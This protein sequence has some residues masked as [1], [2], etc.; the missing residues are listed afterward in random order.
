[1]LF[2][3]V[4]VGG[5]DDDG[6]KKK[7]TP[8]GATVVVVV[9]V[10]VVPF[11]MFECE[12]DN[13]ERKKDGD[14]GGGDIDDGTCGGD[15]GFS[16]TATIGDTE[17]SDGGKDNGDELD[18][19]EELACTNGAAGGGG[20]AGGV[21]PVVVEGDGRGE[22]DLDGDDTKDGDKEPGYGKGNDG[23]VGRCGLATCNR[24]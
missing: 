17:N 4:V 5:D 24:K 10:R 6:D 20:A 22:T 16:S 13:E 15:G 12:G 7:S 18:K 21:E 14:D 23:L 1:M 2:S 11:G 19:G 3:V 9:G 8:V